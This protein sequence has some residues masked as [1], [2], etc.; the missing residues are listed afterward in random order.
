MD[1]SPAARRSA[2]RVRRRRVVGGH[3]ALANDGAGT[4]LDITS[5]GSG[6]ITLTKTHEPRYFGGGVISSDT[7]G[8]DAMNQIMSGMAGRPTYTG[9]IFKLFAGVWRGPSVTIDEDDLRGAISVQTRTTWAQRFNTVIGT[10][11][12]PVNNWQAASYPQ[13]QGASYVSDDMGEILQTELDLPF[14][15]RASTAQRIATIKLNLS[16]QEMVVTYPGKLTCAQF[17]PMD[18]LYI[19]NT[20][21]GWSG[22]V[23]EV[24]TWKVG[25]QNGADAPQP[26]IDMMLQET[27]SSCYDWDS[28]AEIV[29]TPTPQT[30]LPDP[31]TVGQVVGLAISSISV[32][33]KGG[34]TTYRATASW[35]PIGNAFVTNGGWVH[36]QYRLT[37]TTIWNSLPPVPG[38]ATQADIFSGALSTGYDLRCWLENSLGITSQSDPVELDNLSLGSLGGVGFTQDWDNWT[39][40]IGA[41]KDYGNWTDSIGATNDW[42]GFS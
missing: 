15:Q 10:Y 17:Q 4:A 36:F 5:A 31:F 12:S 38:S 41:T 6:T 7:A 26:G 8:G 11:I 23:F 20:R 33:T 40:A 25:F 34:D 35:D 32:M 9:G 28:S 30:N 29:V 42:G 27:A 21:M 24:E 37:G 3:L 22:K 39:D 16:R 13:V 19:N 1:C 18:T 14:T 2:P